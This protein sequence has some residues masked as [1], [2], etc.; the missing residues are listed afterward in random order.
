MKQVSVARLTVI[1]SIASIF[2]GLGLFPQFSFGAIII[3]ISSPDIIKPV[4]SGLY[5]GKTE[6]I[7]SNI[8]NHTNFKISA[9]LRLINVLCDEG[10]IVG[11]EQKWYVLNYVRN[12]IESVI[13]FGLWI[14]RD[15]DTDS[16]DTSKGDEW[17]RDEADGIH[18]DDLK[19]TSIPLGIINSCE[20]L[21]VVTSY[22]MDEETENW[23]QSDTM[24]FDIEITLEEVKSTC[25]PC[26][27]FLWLWIKKI[28]KPTWRMKYWARAC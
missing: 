10:T 17:I 20:I 7:I 22:H 27:R 8:P 6:Y 28:L 3:D 9:S 1:F 2:L 4:I 26:T 25:R 11:P 19:D 13:T 24:T 5:P 18:I 14:D 23:A 16:C 21:T 12:D 15:G